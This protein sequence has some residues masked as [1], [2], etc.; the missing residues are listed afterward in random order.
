MSS[1]SSYFALRVC[2]DAGAL[3]WW[4][5]ARRA[6]ADA[7]LAI[8]SL[9]AG[10]TRVELS[11]SD[12]RLVLNWARRLDGWPRDGLAPVW[13]YPEPPAAQA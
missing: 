2:P 8:R 7:P 9:L 1:L 6:Q 4:T 12:A 3:D 10:R 11:A 13:I 5:A